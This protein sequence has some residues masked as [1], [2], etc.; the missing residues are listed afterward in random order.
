MVEA[1]SLLLTVAL[2]DLARAFART[3]TW[4]WIL[5]LASAMLASLGLWA[6]LGYSWVVAALVLVIAASWVLLVGVNPSVGATRIWPALVLTVLVV[7]LATGYASEAHLNAQI[8]A[9]YESTPI[10]G[11]GVS[12]R[13]ALAAA[14]VTLFI[15]RSANLIVRGAIV[16]RAAQAESS[17]PD[18]SSRISPIRPRWRVAWKNVELAT[19]ERAQESPRAHNELAGGRVIGPIERILLVALMLSGNAVIVAALVAA[20]GVVRFPEISADRDG[21]LNAETFLVGSL[22]SWTIAAAAAALIWAAGP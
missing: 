17:S 14:S 11:A 6:M 20:K 3:V 10:A 18:E 8:L 5:G 22:T 15:T 1:A 9:L 2:A 16:S 19:I 21:G 7:V 12:W 4:C 13:V